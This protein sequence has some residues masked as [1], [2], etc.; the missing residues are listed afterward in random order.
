MLAEEIITEAP[1][2]SM[3]GAGYEILHSDAKGGFARVDDIMILFVLV[4][5][6][7]EATVPPPL[8]P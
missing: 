3:F 7:A 5:V 6:S 2:N 1:Q 8:E 4:R